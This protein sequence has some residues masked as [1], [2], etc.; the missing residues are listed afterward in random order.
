MT[1][2]D[3]L[4]VSY[5]EVYT[6]VTLEFV[7][8]IAM[9][10]EKEPMRWKL[11]LAHEIVR[12]YHGAEIADKEQEWFLR[13]FSTRRAPSDIPVIQV[14]PGEQ[15][16]FYLVKHFFGSHKS[17]SELRRLFEQGAISLNDQT[18]RQAEQ[19]VEVHNGDVFRVGKRTWFRLQ[20]DH[21]RVIE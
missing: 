3:H 1:L 21:S 14:E 12:R 11:F 13:T 19:V 2:P 7:E 16:A 9:R 10:V 4:I 18:L 8:E 15:P 20:V 5:L 6:D 17:H